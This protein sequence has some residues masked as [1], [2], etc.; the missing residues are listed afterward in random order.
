MTNNKR[1]TPCLP[2]EPE[3][4]RQRIIGISFQSAPPGGAA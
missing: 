2:P 4:G 1:P 3:Q